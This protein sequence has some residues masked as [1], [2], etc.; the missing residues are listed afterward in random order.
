MALLMGCNGRCDPA[1]ECNPHRI[2]RTKFEQWQ[3]GTCLSEEYQHL[4]LCETHL[5]SFRQV[6]SQIAPQDHSLALI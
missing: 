3:Y 6:K 4:E 2:E 1:L 5:L